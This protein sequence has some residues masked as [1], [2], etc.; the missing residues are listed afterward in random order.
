MSKTSNPLTGAK[1]VVGIGGGIAAYKAVELV[2]MLTKVD[3]STRAVM[4]S[5]A[6]EFVGELTLQALTG[7]SV[8]TNLFDLSQES[9]IGHIEVA[10]QADLII[11]APASANLI[12]RMAAG[13]ANDALTAV[14]LA[15]R[16]PILIAPSMNV[17]MWQNPLTQRN[18]RQLIDVRGVHVVGPGDGF[19]A[20]RWTGPGRLAE[21]VDI[22]EAACRVLTRQDLAGVRIVVSA[23]PTRERLDPVRFLGNRSSGKMGYALATAAARRGAEV[24]IVS[25]PVALEQPPGIEVVRV[26]SARE[27]K[28]AIFDL[29]DSADA[30]IMVA[31]VADYR[32]ASISEHK[33][34]KS[35]IGNE[36]TLALV[37]NPDILAELGQQRGDKNRPLLVGFAAETESVVSSARKK[38]VA[39]RC[40]LIV[41]NDVS[42]D[43]TGFESDTNAVTLVTHSDTTELPLGSKAEIAHGVLDSLVELLS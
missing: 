24:T 30:I 12:A 2:R 1:V 28:T 5:S 13:M 31:A 42:R 8:F 4:T 15:T 25:G 21:P 19:L 14:L 3:A 7:Q 9:E 41:A 29:R 27:M 18:V 35:D 20:C 16:A 34:K 43:D 10:D 37:R 32:P 38:L 23:G 40:D 6:T 39:K 17:N 22:L 33:L 36:L 26:Q 11:V